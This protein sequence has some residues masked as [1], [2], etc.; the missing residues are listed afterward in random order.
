MHKM[1]DKQIEE[2]ICP[3]CYSQWQMTYDIHH[4]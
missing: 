1:L 3:C 2:F 4:F